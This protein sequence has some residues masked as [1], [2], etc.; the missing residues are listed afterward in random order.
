MIRWRQIT[1]SIS[2]MLFSL[3]MA[4]PALG[5]EKICSSGD[6]FAGLF[7]APNGSLEA[8]YGGKILLH[9]LFGVIVFPNLCFGWLA[10]PIYWISIACLWIFAPKYKVYAGLIALAGLF[11]GVSGT[12]WTVSHGLLVDEGGVCRLYLN[13]LYVGFWLWVAAQGTIALSS[14]LL[15]CKPRTTRSRIRL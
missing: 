1:T 6:R 4:L 13:D 15:V 5:F 14:L 12:L 10:N 2:L 9:G 8:W 11:V 7:N 3:A